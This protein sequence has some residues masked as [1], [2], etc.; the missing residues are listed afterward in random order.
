MCFNSSNHEPFSQSA[1]YKKNSQSAVCGV[2]VNVKDIQKK[3][4]N[5]QCNG[6]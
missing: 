1:L 5:A 3:I 6:F 4:N 2:E